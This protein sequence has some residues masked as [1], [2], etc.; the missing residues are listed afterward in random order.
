MNRD[1]AIRF[2]AGVIAILVG[3][4]ITYVVSAVA[5]WIGGAS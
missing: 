2:V 3:A 1:L 5:R 4:A